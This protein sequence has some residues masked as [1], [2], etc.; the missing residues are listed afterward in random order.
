MPVHCCS[1]PRRS[2]W[3]IGSPPASVMRA[4]RI[5]HTVATLVGQRVIGLALGY[6]DVCDHDQLRH[7]PVF[8]V[9]AGKLEPRRKRALPSGARARSIAWSM[10]PRR[11]PPLRPTA[12]TRSATTWAPSER[13]FVPLFLEA[14]A[15][16][17]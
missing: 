10:R 7:D 2:V 5:E 8:A 9:L 3:S 12:F 1:G 14:H 4:E 15:H 6:E 16:A 11:G 13:L 17:A